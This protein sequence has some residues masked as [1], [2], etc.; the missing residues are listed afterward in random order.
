MRANDVARSFE[1][2]CFAANLDHQFEAHSNRTEL[3]EAVAADLSDATE[4]LL[5]NGAMQNSEDDDGL[6]ARDLEIL[7]YHT[8]FEERKTRKARKTHKHTL[9]TEQQEAQDLLAADEP[10]Q[11]QQQEQDEA[12]K[13][14][15]ENDGNSQ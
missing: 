10:E 6:A 15:D 5:Q 2:L 11:E 7:D 12:D 4:L 1:A 13:G 3:H 9:D 8:G 14:G